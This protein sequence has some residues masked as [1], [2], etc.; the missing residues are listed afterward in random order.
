MDS[1][2]ELVGSAVGIAEGLPDSDAAA[3]SDGTADGVG[4]SDSR[5]V[6][7]ATA[8]RLAVLVGI[9]DADPRDVDVGIDVAVVLN[10]LRA[11]ALLFPVA[12]PETV[13]AVVADAVGV[14]EPDTVGAT[15][16]LP[17]GVPP[18]DTVAELDSVAVRV[19]LADAVSDGPAVVV[20]T[21]DSEGVRAAV[22]V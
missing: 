8:E 11:V 3:D 10:E 1:L 12:L 17:E 2:E 16:E 19:V 14:A 18:L 22:R 9:D 21:D 4:S 15:L 20:A 7:E 5:A 6:P 13:P